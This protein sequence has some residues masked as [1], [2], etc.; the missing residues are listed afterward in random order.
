MAATGETGQV[1]GTPRR[2]RNGSRRYRS[3]ILVASV[4]DGVARPL[5]A[6]RAVLDQELRS[7]DY[8]IETEL[9]VTV[10]SVL[11]IRATISPSR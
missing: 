10:R 4:L 6:T 8:C 9:F 5:A 7:G 2:G 11:R 3:G 1:T